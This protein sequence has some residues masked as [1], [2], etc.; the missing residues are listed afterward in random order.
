MYVYLLHLALQSKLFAYSEGN[1]DCKFT[2]LQKRQEIQAIKI[3]YLRKKALHNALTQVALNKSKDDKFSC[4][5]SEVQKT[6][7]CAECAQDLRLTPSQA[8]LGLDV[9]HLSRLDALS[10]DEG[11][12]VS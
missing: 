6:L 10:H 2:F 1:F 11:D 5:F 8:L 4:I 12:T 3:S 7:L 9:R